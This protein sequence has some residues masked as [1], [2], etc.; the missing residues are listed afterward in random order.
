MVNGACFFL[1]AIAHGGEDRGIWDVLTDGLKNE[2]RVQTGS[3]FF[4][5]LPPR[6]TD[7]AENACVL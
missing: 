4:S 1:W 5:D 6:M 2:I 3:E 7:P